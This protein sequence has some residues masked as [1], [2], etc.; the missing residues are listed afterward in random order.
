[1][2]QIK[3]KDART[4]VGVIGGIA[5]GKSLVTRFL[6]ERGATVVDA[7]S[8]AHEVLS[9]PEVIGEIC[10]IFGDDVLLSSTVGNGTP[11]RIDRKKVA[12]LVFGETDSH[13]L[14]RQ[15]L[16]EVVQPRIR[17]RLMSIIQDWKARNTCGLLALDIP[18]LFERNWHPVCDEI[19]FVDTPRERR[20]TYAA[21]RG[22]TPE[23]LKEREAAQLG[24]EEKKSRST[25]VIINNGTL[26]ELERQV[27][28][29]FLRT[30][31]GDQAENRDGRGDVAGRA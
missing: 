16:E 27:D 28:A 11:L 15:A 22:W 6:H 19:W 5:S 9:D 13:R 3:S 24:I 21:A 4:I 26:E 8:V 7:D 12:S 18:L 10:G 29:A 17:A 14:R 31:V 1:M 23:Q 30:T 25:H 20:E 2:S